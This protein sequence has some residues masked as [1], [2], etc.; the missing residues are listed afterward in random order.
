MSVRCLVQKHVRV[1]F[2][3]ENPTS[4]NKIVGF[5][6]VI[7]KNAN[8]EEWR[9]PNDEKFPPIVL[10]AMERQF[11]LGIHSEPQSL[12]EDQGVDVRMRQILLPDGNGDYLGIVPLQSMPLIRMAQ[13]AAQEIA[14]ADE[15]QD[16]YRRLPEIGYPV[17]GGVPR[18]AGLETGFRKFVVTGFYRA[19]VEASLRASAMHRGVASR[20]KI[21]RETLKK[22]AQFIARCDWSSHEQKAHRGYVW[23][24]VD[25]YL[26]Q[27]G[28][29]AESLSGEDID[30]MESDLDKGLLDVSQRGPSWSRAFADWV[31]RKMKS[32]PV[33]FKDG[34]PLYLSGVNRNYLRK[35]IREVVS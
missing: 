10:N 3:S 31:Y 13:K 16:V 14:P 20:L 15:K 25:H 4:A 5:S 18:T 8:G 19:S 35:I 21:D 22:Y 24:I 23:R 28:L 30:G 32:E 27:A 34:Q 1:F 12:V 11:L 6:S 7:I 26:R 33:E 29:M 17:G 9:K 2:T